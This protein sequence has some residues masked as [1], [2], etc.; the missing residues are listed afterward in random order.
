MRTIS[1]TPSSTTI[2]ETARILRHPLHYPILDFTANPCAVT[3]RESDRRLSLLPTNSRASAL[4]CNVAILRT[5]FEEKR[6]SVHIQPDYPKKIFAE[7]HPIVRR[8]V[9]PGKTESY[10]ERVMLL[11]RVANSSY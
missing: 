4:Y 9:K 3:S 2:V 8:P 7:K 10:D 5:F 1:T 11:Q 6:A